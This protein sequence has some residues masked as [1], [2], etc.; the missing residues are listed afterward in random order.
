MNIHLFGAS[1]KM[2]CAIAKQMATSDC[3]QHAST[4]EQA[5][6]FIDFSSPTA[7]MIHLNLA[8]KLKKPL[9]LGTTGLTEEIYRHIA[10]SAKHI[11]VLHSPN[12]SLGMALCF[13]SI[14]IFGRF[15]VENSDI[16]I[17]ETH[18]IQK[19]DTP[20]GTAL[21]M[22]EAIPKKKNQILIRSLRIEDTIGEHRITFT[23]SKEQIELTH[24]AFS[25]EAFA[26]GAL[27]AALFLYSQPPGQYTMKDV[28]LQDCAILKEPSKG[29]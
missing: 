12:F 2:G 3:F 23:N 21:A 16:E 22:A 5:D 26:Q 20:S 17:I 27:K 18:H 29:F 14:R 8:E 24:R 9:I 25:R 15:L 11:P 19:K 7:T 28:I 10:A 13:E 4:I 1:G 6:L